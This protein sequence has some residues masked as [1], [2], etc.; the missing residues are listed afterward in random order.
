M[1]S[2]N[3]RRLIR[4]A[5]I[6]SSSPANGGV[7]VLLSKHGMSTNYVPWR[8]HFIRGNINWTNEHQQYAISVYK[9]HYGDDSYCPVCGRSG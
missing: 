3:E 4:E 5:I 1:I 6:I 2:E 7:R 9:E 8:R